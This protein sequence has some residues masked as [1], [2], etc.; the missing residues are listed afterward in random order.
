MNKQITIPGIT[1]KSCG[2][3]Q[4]LAIQTKIVK[5]TDLRLICQGCGIEEDILALGGDKYTQGKKEI[6]RLTKE[7][8]KSLVK[9][10]KTLPKN[11]DEW[12]VVVTNPKHPFTAALLSGFVILLMELS[13]FGIFMAITWVLGNLILNPIGWVLIP[14]V[15]G[16]AFHYRDAFAKDKITELKDQLNALQEQ[17]NTGTLTD[18]EYEQAKDELLASHFS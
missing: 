6:K 5:I 2:G 18:V 16:T 12:S 4:N 9:L 10:R 11:K 14:L 15:V 7:L 1:C 17:H 3:T 8:S 13:G